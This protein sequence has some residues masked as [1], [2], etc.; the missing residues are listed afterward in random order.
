MC[1][2]SQR[3]RERPTKSTKM[4]LVKMLALTAV[5]TIILK[6]LNNITGKCLSYSITLQHLFYT[7]L[8]FLSFNSKFTT[9]NRKT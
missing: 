2:R 9:K 1:L 5:I 6:T 7:T 4:R 8:T 3:I